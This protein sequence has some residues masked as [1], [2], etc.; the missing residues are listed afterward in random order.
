MVLAVVGLVYAESR[1]WLTREYWAAASSDLRGC[2][3]VEW[4]SEPGGGD[5]PLVGLEQI[6]VDGPQLTG[7]ALHPDG[8]T[9][10][11][12]RET[13]EVV[14]HGADG[15]SVA[16]DLS[17]RV[18]IDRDQ[19]LLGGVV[20]EAGNWLYL[21]FTGL[22][23][24]TRVEAFP[25]VD[26]LPVN[27]PVELLEVA[28]DDEHHNGGGIALDDEGAL[29]IGIG[30]GGIIGD[31]D[32]NAQ[33]R[34]ELLGKVLRIEPTPG[35][36]EPYVVPASNPFVGDPDGA[37][38]IFAIGVRN[39]FRISV[40]GDEILVGDVGHNCVE[41]VS[42]LH[43]GDDAGANLGWNRFEGTRT[44]VGGGVDEHHEPTFQ[45][46]HDPGWC[47]TVGAVAY[48]GDAV[49]ALEGRIVTGDFCSGRLLAIDPDGSDALD[50]G[51]DVG[52]AIVQ[53]TTDHEGEVLVVGYDGT[54]RRLTEPTGGP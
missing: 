43:R 26:G 30:D 17:G 51:V 46:P 32:N 23:G 28:Q 14:L 53:L 54:V 19:G 12:L 5:R 31:Q 9:M 8:D 15:P 6:V 34:D 2:G 16:L 52:P 1:G 40:H 24:E 42:T 41:E 49:E 44:F 22:E 10:Y 11:L 45:Y 29:W 25:L 21:I 27:E 35:A 13:G 48:A 4:T 7:L 47:A 50:L 38:E 20:D 37:D 33:A 36:A 18:T 3:T 39:P